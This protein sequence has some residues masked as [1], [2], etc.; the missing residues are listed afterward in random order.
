MKKN[1]PHVLG[2]Q[3]MLLPSRGDHQSNR[4]LIHIDG[5]DA[6][7]LHVHEYNLYART[8]KKIVLHDLVPRPLE[9]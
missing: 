7:S 2:C 6:F 8:I 4:K 9:R 5:F 3:W 1:Y